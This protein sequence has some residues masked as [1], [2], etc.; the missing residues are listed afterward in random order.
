MGLHRAPADN[1]SVSDLG[2]SVALS[3]QRK[4]LTFA[5]SQRAIGV[6]LHAS[7]A[8]KILV[9]GAL[10]ELRRLGHQLSIRPALTDAIGAY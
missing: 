2:A 10:V 6:S 7:R 8:F 3:Y 5:W 1:S 9:N 4:Y